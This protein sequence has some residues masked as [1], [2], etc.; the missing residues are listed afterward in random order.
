MKF[1]WSHYFPRNHG[2]DPPYVAVF[3]DP[4]EA[5]SLKSARENSSALLESRVPKNHPQAFWEQLKSP[6]W[7]RHLVKFEKP[8]SS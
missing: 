4:S 5:G 3:P 6:V 7:P 8:R 1:W 2:P